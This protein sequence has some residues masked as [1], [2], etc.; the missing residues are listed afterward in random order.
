MA[1]HDNADQRAFVSKD[2]TWWQNLAGLLFVACPATF[3][4]GT[5]VAW[6]M[7]MNY[8]E[9]EWDDS[10]AQPDV[11]ELLASHLSQRQRERSSHA[12]QPSGGEGAPLS[13]TQ[14]RGGQQPPCQPI[15]PFA[16]AG[17]RLASS[18]ESLSAG[19]STD[20][21]KRRRAAAGGARN[22]GKAEEVVDGERSRERGGS[23]SLNKKL[24]R[25]RSNR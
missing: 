25:A 2:R 21:E 5:I 13:R 12:E 8:G 22:A 11:D 1:A 4:C 16:G 23:T 17:R 10:V 9:C 7:Y 18:S 19:G 24:V 15:Q 6:S 14:S 20:E 3:F